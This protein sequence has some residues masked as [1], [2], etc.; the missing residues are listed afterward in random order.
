MAKTYQFLKGYCRVQA[1]GPHLEKLLNLAL[2][3]SIYLWDVKKEGADKILFSVSNRGFRLMQ[4]YAETTQSKLQILSRKG[5]DVL[6]NSTK[7]HRVFSISAF[8]CVTVILVSASFIWTVEI[9][10]GDFVDEEK[11]IRQLSS[12]GLSRGSFRKTVD[13]TRIS[14]QLIQDFDEILWA[15]VELKGT[16][17]MV[18]LVP[19]TP[20][21]QVIPKEIPTNIVA[22]KDGIIQEITAENGEA[23]VRAGD[24]VVKD[25]ILISGLIPSPTVG[26]RYVHSIGQIR[27]VTW[28]TCTVEQKLYRYDKILTGEESIHREVELP[29]L[30]IPL[31]FRQTIDFYNYDSIIKEKNLFFLT[32]RETVSQEYT[33]QKTPITEQEAVEE[34][35]QKLEEELKKKHIS[36]TISQKISHSFI[37]NE[38]LS[39]TLLAQCE[40]ELGVEK[41]ITKPTDIQ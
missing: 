13:Y 25:Q 16:K 2:C 18:T 6:W 4:S 28:E 32:Y 29:F 8:L 7:R 3:N 24:T 23:M 34:A 14:N 21:P 31:D 19:R 17:L 26:S 30:K 27:A 36:E 1:E 33:L 35:K 41:E 12:Y 5:V 9:E 10:G 37:D 15:N 38:T 11:I 40:E 39:V 20:A 22:K